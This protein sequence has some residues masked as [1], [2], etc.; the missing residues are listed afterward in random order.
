MADEPN[1][2]AEY[3]VGNCK[4]PKHTQFQPGKS[5]NPNGRPKGSKNLA[6]VVLRE[7]R[8]KVRINGPNGSRSVTKIEAAVLQLANSAA[9]GNTAAQ[10]HFFALLQT[11]EESSNRG[12]AQTSVNECDLTVIQSILRRVQEHW[13][14][15][16]TDP[17][18]EI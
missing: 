2:P 10:R 7:G 18:Q 4:P 5:G 9:Q 8:K 6:S 16:E 17:T 3:E 15:T 13:P 1:D 12:D 14:S 11:S